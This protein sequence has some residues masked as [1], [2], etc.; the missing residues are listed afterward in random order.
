M[1]EKPAT[2]CRL[3]RSPSSPNARLLVLVAPQAKWADRVHPVEPVVRVSVDLPAELALLA[4]LA[5]KASLEP[6][7]R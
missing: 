5:N 7:A 1:K 6:L 4:S 2:N 3:E